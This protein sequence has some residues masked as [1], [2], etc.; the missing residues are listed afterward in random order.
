MKCI[1]CNKETNNP[2]FCSRSCS[3]TFHNKHKPKRKLKNKCFTCNKPIRSNR[4]YCK[5]CFWEHKFQPNKTLADILVPKDYYQTYKKSL[6]NHA[7]RIAKKH[8]MLDKCAL[9]DYNH[10]VEACHIK[11]VASFSKD[12]LILEVN[13]PKNLIGLCPNH[14]KDL[15]LGFL[16]L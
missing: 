11:P 15:D 6:Y 1:Y 3:I 5:K 7:R 8:N 2:K 16:K 4:K 9:C 13:N 10:H 14:H 12:T